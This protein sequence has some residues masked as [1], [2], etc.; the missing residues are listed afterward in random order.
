MK[1]VG[2]TFWNPPNTGAT[3]SSGFT[4]RGAGMREIFSSFDYLNEH[5]IFWATYQFHYR[6]LH[7]NSQQ[8]GREFLGGPTGWGA[9]SVRCLKD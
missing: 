7:Y 6:G 4:G 8:V 1:E 2:T 3:N 9:I 5:G